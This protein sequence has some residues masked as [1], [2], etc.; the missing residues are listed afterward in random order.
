M[1]HDKHN[2]TKG[3]KYSPSDRASAAI[4]Q[5]TKH[6][7]GGFKKPFYGEGMNQGNTTPPTVKTNTKPLGPASDPTSKDLMQRPGVD[8]GNPSTVK[9]S[10]K[11]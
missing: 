6:L 9:R 4:K 1:D 3:G 11:P 8:A 5:S 7:D 2:L 10:S